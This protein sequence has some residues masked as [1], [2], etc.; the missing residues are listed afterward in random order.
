MLS[1]TESTSNVRLE[2]EGEVGQLMLE[3]DHLFEQYLEL[4]DQY[5]TERIKLSTTLSSGFLSL[6]Q[7]NFS[8]TLGRR[9]GQD[10][11]DERM[12]ALRTVYVLPSNSKL[13]GEDGE[14]VT[15]EGVPPHSEKPARNGIDDTAEPSVAEPSKPACS[16]DEKEDPHLGRRPSVDP[17]RWFGILVPQPLRTA[18]AHFT[19]AVVGPLPRIA[20]LA[21]KLRAL[22]IRIGRTRKAIKK[23]E[24]G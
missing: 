18:Q 23:L 4:L 8:S 20:S 3:L 14:K 16:E 24:K 1:T 9:Y 22:E 12:Q 13:G 21:K 6:A 5:Q 7:A 17:I 11:Y 2:E 10:Y 19:E 15:I